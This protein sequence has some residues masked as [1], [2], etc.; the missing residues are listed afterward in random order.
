[1]S[2]PITVF[3]VDDHE[4]VRRVVVELLESD[5]VIRVIGEADGVE[6]GLAGILAAPPDVALIDVR[7][8]DGSGIE[9][10]RALRSRKP[11]IRCVILTA[12]DDDDA[13]MAAVIGDAAGYV[14]KSIRG[15]R[16]VEIVKQ[17]ASGASALD[18]ELVRLVRDRLRR[19]RAG[20]PRLASLIPREREV[21]RLIVDG[22]TDPQIGARLALTEQAVANHVSG[23]LGALDLQAR[24]EAPMVRRWLE[25][26]A[27]AVGAPPGPSR[28]GRRD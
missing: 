3:L 7:L 8:P 5:P 22:L 14:L 25:A 13:M 19:S 6:R 26:V 12:N 4:A 23:L 17:V 24:R 9:L 21:L 27:D 10:C 15:S 2:E 18:P 11:L 1:M 20:D 16:L 28:T